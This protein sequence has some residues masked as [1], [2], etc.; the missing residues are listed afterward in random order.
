MNFRSH[1]GRK[2]PT[3]NSSFDFCLNSIRKVQ[4]IKS[5]TNEIVRNLTDISAADSSK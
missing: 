2:L 1:L 4:L 3:A 5:C